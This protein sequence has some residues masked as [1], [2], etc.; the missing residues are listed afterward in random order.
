M[1]QREEQTKG[2][3]EEVKTS[4]ERRWAETRRDRG[5]ISADNKVD[6]VLLLLM[7]RD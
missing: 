7:N 3:K 1:A 5:N 2:V 6:D 4:E